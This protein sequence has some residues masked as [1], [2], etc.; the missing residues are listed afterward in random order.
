MD[1]EEETPS[2]LIEPAGRGDKMSY[3]KLAGGYSEFP[4]R[5]SNSYNPS[6]LS[7]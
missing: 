2:Q 5:L 1:A 6:V 4:G 7:R 3:T